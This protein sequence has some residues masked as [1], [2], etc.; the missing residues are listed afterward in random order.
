VRHAVPVGRTVRLEMERLDTGERV[1]AEIPKE[2][3]RELGIKA[4]D[5]VFLRPRNLQLFAA[6]G[7]I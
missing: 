6:E 3:W 5:L 7:T 2:R 1:L 4:G